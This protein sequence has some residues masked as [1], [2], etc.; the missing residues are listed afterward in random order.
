MIF[1][2]L[3][4]DND[5]GYP[6]FRDH[7]V[8]NG[9]IL[10]CILVFIYELS[11]GENGLTL[12]LH[13][14]TFDPA[15]V[16]GPS[17]LS[18]S[19]LHRTQ[20]LFRH[21]TDLNNFHDVLNIFKSTFI[22][23][24]FMHLFSNIFVLWM[25]GDNVEYAMGHVRYFFFF[26][27]TALIAQFCQIIYSTD[28]NFVSQVGAS[29]AIMA[30]AGVYLVYFSKARVNFFYWWFVFWWGIW[31]VSARLVMM[32]YF[33]ILLVVAYAEDSGALEGE[34][35]ANWAH[36]YGFVSGVILALPLRYARDEKYFRYT[37]AKPIRYK[38]SV[39]KP[40]DDNPDPW[41][42]GIRD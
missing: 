9:F 24:G 32:A 37:P 11:L 36:V 28:L 15:T 10:L 17:F 14:N 41:N 5:E 20:A 12:F 7:F 29:G 19:P 1:L 8:N 13:Y 18:L 22:H 27:G 33:I 30:V 21:L 25:L 3:Y 34:H 23:G 31:D 35:I 6:R 16:L 42:T 39:F 38:G 2:P 26:I 40:H 4:D